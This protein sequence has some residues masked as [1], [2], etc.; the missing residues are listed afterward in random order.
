M[1]AHGGDI[2]CLRWH[3][4]DDTWPSFTNPTLVDPQ[5]DRGLRSKRPERRRNQRRA[6]AFV[7]RGA[8]RDATGACRV[9]QAFDPAT[10][11]LRHQDR[12]ARAWCA[13]SPRSCGSSTTSWCERWQA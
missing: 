2:R 3:S 1:L 12:A 11:R 5:S 10:C 7:L 4:R 6:G 9:C 13:L 8:R